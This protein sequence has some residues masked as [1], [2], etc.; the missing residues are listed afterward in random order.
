M[1]TAFAIVLA[2]TAI[3]APVAPAQAEEP[4][5]DFSAAERALFMTDQFAKLR[6]PL[7]LRYQFRHSGSLEPTFDDTVAMALKAQPGTGRCC[8][9]TGEFLSGERRF[10]LPPVEGASGNPVTLYF[11]ERDVREMQRLTTGKSAYFRKRIRMA[12]YQ[13]AQQRAVTL[14][15]RGKTVAGQEFTVTPYVDDPNRPRFEQFANKRYV[16]TLSD[17]VPGGVY[18]IRAFVAD[19]AKGADAPPLLAE[20]LLIDGATAAR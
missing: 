11:L 14:R 18:G 3:A 12:I 8:D 5:R 6:P 4:A 9:V 2:A 19:T 13:G 7:T 10:E 1:R 16:F 17:A 15:Y 20:E